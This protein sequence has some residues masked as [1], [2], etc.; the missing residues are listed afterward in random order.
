MAH[1]E[2]AKG[3]AEWFGE[4]YSTMLVE[5]LSSLLGTYSTQEDNRREP[6]EWWTYGYQ[7]AKEILRIVR[8]RWVVR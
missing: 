6:V 7:S 8:A 5:H 3:R 4:I 2:A 1:I